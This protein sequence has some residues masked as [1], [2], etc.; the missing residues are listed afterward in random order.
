M[1]SGRR[2]LHWDSPMP[3]APLR[4]HHESP[5][6]GDNR[7]AIR[8]ARGSNLDLNVVYALETLW[9]MHYTRP[10]LC[11]YLYVDKPDGG[12]RK[13][14]ARERLRTINR[15]GVEGM[16]TLSRR[17]GERPLTLNQALAACVRNGAVPIKETKSR[18]FGTS[19][20][21]WRLLRDLCKKHDVPMWSKALTNMWGFKAKVIRAERVGV[22]LAAIYGKGL[23]GRLRR[24]ARTRQIERGWKDGTRV[25][26]TW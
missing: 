3:T 19:D 23:S 7:G 1:R 9:A 5:R 11:G 4:Q 12:R 20:R 2:T 10:W 26:A 21:P 18:T 22:P 24:V 16:A 14:T 25:H 15:W 6:T 8:R 13:M 17:N